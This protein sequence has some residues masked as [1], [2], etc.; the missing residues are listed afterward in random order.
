MTG[1]VRRAAAVFMA[2][3]LAFSAV[4]YSDTAQAA[5][6]KLNRKKATIAVGGS[7]K[8]KLKHAKKKVRWSS[9][10]KAVASVNKKGRVRG[11]KPGTAKI[12]AKCAGKKY[13]CKVTVRAKEKEQEP[14]PSALPTPTPQTSNPP[15][16][17]NGAST[18]SSAVKPAA[19]ADDTL[20]VGQLAV[21]LGMSSGEVEAKLGG[22]PDRVEVSS[23]G[24]NS[25][26]Y[27]PSLDYTNYV[28]IQFEQDKVVCIS[29]ISNYFRYEN[30]LSAGEDTESTLTQKG[31]SSMSAKFDYDAGYVLETDTE[32][33]TAF[34][35]HQ[36]SGTVYAAEIFSKKVGQSD[37]VSLE[38]LAR[39]EAAT[40]DS[41]KQEANAKELFDWACA[42]RVVKGLKAF[43]PVTGNTAQKYAE[44]TVAGEPVNAVSLSERFEA[45]Y[46]LYRGCS[47]I[48]TYRCLDAFGAVVW[49]VDNKP[50]GGYP[51]L[52]LTTDQS[53]AAI[54]EYYLCTGFAGA[55]AYANGSI[56]VLD[57]FYF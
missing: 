26:I 44:G 53:G 2:A 29:T 41:A 22:K 36:G 25:Y 20:G 13:T 47:E 45:G 31:F 1:R 24:Y 35:D 48:T 56:A 8:L 51:K 11:K 7:V 17:P 4:S 5:K 18:Q 10:K 40:F 42:F 3:A 32:Y 9:S 16:F 52:T 30:L 54:G 34:V 55:A 15:N 6:P 33:V 57:L 38:N 49:L 21:T 12:T 46:G 27:N 23:M 28:Q 19:C 39:V 50:A 14:T 37:N 43:A